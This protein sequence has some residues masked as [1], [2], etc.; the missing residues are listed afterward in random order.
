MTN[1]LPQ[2]IIRNIMNDIIMSDLW[3]T[4][5]LDERQILEN[6]LEKYLS[7]PKQEDTTQIE[8]YKEAF[9]DIVEKFVRIYFTDE[10]WDVAEYYIIGEDSP[11]WWDVVLI[12]DDWYVG[13]RDMVTCLQLGIDKDVFFERYDSLD[14]EKWERPIN[15]YH[16]HLKNTD[17]WYTLDLDERQILENILEKHLSL[18]KQKQEAEYNDSQIK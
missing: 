17:L 16:M 15:L 1:K 18:P 5:D 13:I 2:E 12:Y 14:L 8:N 6:I 7:L 11:M 9:V 10:D 4:L 3:Y